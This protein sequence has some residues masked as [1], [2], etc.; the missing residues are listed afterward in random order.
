[1]MSFKWIFMIAKVLY[2]Y[3]LIFTFSQHWKNHAVQTKFSSN[4]CIQS[5][6]LS[7]WES[8]LGYVFECNLCFCDMQ[9]TLWLCQT[10]IPGSCMCLAIIPSVSFHLVVQ[11]LGLDCKFFCSTFV[12]RDNKVKKKW[13]K[14]VRSPEESFVLL[15]F[16]K[17]IKLKRSELSLFAHKTNSMT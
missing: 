16:T 6:D 10:Y 1:M 11:N 9:Q 15:L 4:T 5:R 12:Y 8:N 14:F 13:T 7:P 3:F 2:I 17:A